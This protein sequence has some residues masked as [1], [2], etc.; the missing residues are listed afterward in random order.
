MN[1]FDGRLGP[2]KT[3]E[4]YPGTIRWVDKEGTHIYSPHSPMYS[5]ALFMATE[6]WDDATRSWRPIYMESGSD[7]DMPENSAP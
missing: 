5:T 7:A 1:L 6:V 3:E 4:H 2:R